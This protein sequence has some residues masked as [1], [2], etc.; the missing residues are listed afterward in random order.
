V[1]SEQLH[2]GVGVHGHHVVA[3]GRLH[4]RHGVGLAAQALLHEEVAP[5]LQV[6]AAVVAHEALGV[7]QLVPG[8]HDGAAAVTR[9]NRSV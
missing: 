3:L 8:L 5:L 9:D 4:A 1:D 7:V 2:L 6:H